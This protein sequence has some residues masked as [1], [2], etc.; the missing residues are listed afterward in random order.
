MVA[1]AKAPIGTGAAVG[2]GTPGTQES[3]DPATAAI[4]RAA[5]KG[6]AIKRAA[7]SREAIRGAA[8]KVASPG[9][10]V[11]AAATIGATVIVG[12]AINR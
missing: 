11:A 6:A 2:V 7:A 9:A 5:I 12:A 1:G 3:A 10:K 8:I 4:R